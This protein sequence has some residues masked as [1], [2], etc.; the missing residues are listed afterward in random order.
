MVNNSEISV[1]KS[2]FFAQHELSLSCLKLRLFGGN[3]KNKV[4]VMQCV[5][6][7]F[8]LILFQHREVST[9]SDHLRITKHICLFFPFKFNFFP[10][11]L[12]GKSA[13][14]IKKYISTDNYTLSNNVNTKNGFEWANEKKRSNRR[15]IA[16]HLDIVT[17]SM[18]KQFYAIC[19]CCSRFA[20]NTTSTFSYSQTAV[21]NYFLSKSL[22][23]CT[24]HNSSGWPLITRLPTSWHLELLK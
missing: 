12:D 2:I 9:I 23:F 13:D 20:I 18:R 10:L 1:L 14:R 17:Q 19:F 4:H 21:S 3:C 24:S 22:Y 15:Y 16:K 6:S 5:F 8:C 7:L 11:C